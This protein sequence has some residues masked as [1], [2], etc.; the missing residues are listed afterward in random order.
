VGHRA[1]GLDGLAVVG[2][3]FAAFGFKVVLLCWFQLMVRWTLPRF[4]ADQ[5][6]NLGWKLLLPLS[7]ANIMVTVGQPVS[8]GQALATLDT[9]DLQTALATAQQNVANAQASY[10]KQ[11]LAGSDTQRQLAETRRSTASDIASAQTSLT[12][13]RTNYAAAKAGIIALTLATAN[14]MGRYGVTANAIS[15][16]AQTRMIDSIPTERRRAG[17]DDERSPDNIATVVA[18]LAS[19]RSGWITGR[20]VHSMGYEVSLYNNPEPIARIIGTQPWGLDDLAD[21]VERSF[22]PL[23]GKKG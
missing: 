9:T 6:M 15:P 5:L 18:Y 16:G 11:V 7:L 19:E 2:L 12:K 17:L 4:R 8:A 23:L 22:G 21:Q 13:V 1:R 14:S 20:I 3:Q 10:Q